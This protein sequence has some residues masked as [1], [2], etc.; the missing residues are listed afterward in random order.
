MCTWVVVGGW[1]RILPIYAGSDFLFFQ[2]HDLKKKNKKHPLLND[3]NPLRV[4]RVCVV[5]MFSF[6]RNIQRN[7]GKNMS[8][9]NHG[10]MLVIK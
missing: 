7:L 4:L 3:K 5:N 1:C 2:L 8:L 10:E 6:I 9:T